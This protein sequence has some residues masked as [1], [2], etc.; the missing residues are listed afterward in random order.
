MRLTLNYGTIPTVAQFERAY[1]ATLGTLDEPFNVSNCDVVGN[2]SFDSA[3]LYAEC[4]RLCERADECNDVEEYEKAE[5]LTSWVSCALY[6][7]GIEWI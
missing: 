6:C 7:L 3:S 4:E 5:H 2:C 1:E